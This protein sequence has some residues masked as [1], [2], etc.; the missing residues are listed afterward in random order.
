MIAI[1]IDKF[2]QELIELEL[3][4]YQYRRYIL[5]INSANQY[6]EHRNISLLI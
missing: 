4:L 1:N 2:N 5:Q 3:I 6:I